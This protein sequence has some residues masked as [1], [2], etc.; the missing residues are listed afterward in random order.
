MEEF[1]FLD[2]SPTTARRKGR[3]SNCINEDDYDYAL[4]LRPG[5]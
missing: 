2:E 4:E 1:W 3:E 5:I